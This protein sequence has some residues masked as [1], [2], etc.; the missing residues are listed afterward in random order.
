MA[1]KEI[2]IL[3]PTA[4]VEKL[5]KIAA[6][7]ALNRRRF[8][9]SLGM[10]SAAAGAG[11]LSGCS[12][13]NT[14]TATTA[15]SGQINALNFVLNFKYLEATFYASIATG[16]DLPS[17]SIASSGAVTNAPGKL[18][19]TGTNAQQIT[20]LINEIYYD[21]KSHVATLISLLG[22]AAV[23][24]PA[25][26]LGAYATVNAN[27]ALS[28]ARLLEDVGT[29]AMIG[30]TAALSNSNL[31]LVSQILG[32]ESCHAGMLRLVSIQNPTIAAYA[33]ADSLDVAPIDLGSASASAAGPTAAGG[34][35]ATA[36]AATSN[37]TTPAGMAFNRT[38][39]QVLAIVYG[40]NGVV[41]ASGATSGG[42]FPSGV[43]GSI[44]S[45]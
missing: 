6:G 27:N 21:E 19:F 10:T 8:L 18:V 1:S 44:K 23:F 30:A 45:V 4:T 14:V 32:I 22:S 33:K 25:I 26:N 24:R 16:G 41:A 37:S 42:F 15:S 28:V 36:G 31:T 35:F 2:E 9:A 29:T 17:S 3:D 43:N 5:T 38:S 20:D 7:R 12:T 11:L 13:S 40:S 34:I 39:S